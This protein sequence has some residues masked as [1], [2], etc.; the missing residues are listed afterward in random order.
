MVKGEEKCIQGFLLK[1]RN[2]VEDL[3]IHGMK[4][5]ELI[6]DEVCGMAWTRFIWFRT[7]SIGGLQEIG[8]LNSRVPSNA[9][10][11]LTS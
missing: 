11:S 3:S 7:S 4:K 2:H 6:L 10:S 5:L 8:H 1:E 9:G